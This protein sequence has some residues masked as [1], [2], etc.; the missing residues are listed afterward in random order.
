M[1]T[2]LTYTYRQRLSQLR[3]SYIS[4]HV[5]MLF[6]TGKKGTSTNTELYCTCLNQAYHRS[7][8]LQQCHYVLLRLPLLTSGA[9]Q[10]CTLLRGFDSEAILLVCPIYLEGEAVI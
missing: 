10:K 1:M 4:Y 2:L 9:F 7:V 3:T 8:S 5:T 6:W